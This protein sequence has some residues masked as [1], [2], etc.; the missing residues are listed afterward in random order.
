MGVQVSSASEKDS[1]AAGIRF[2]MWTSRG[3]DYDDGHAYGQS[4]LA[5]VLF[6]RE[7]AT[8]LN[9]TGV[10]VR[11]CH[12]GIIYTGLGD[13]FLKNMKAKFATNMGDNIGNIA[14]SMYLVVWEN[15]VF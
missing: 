6:A 12:P 4:S 10:T 7:L 1:Y 11:S 13:T 15:S 14:F 2:D 5:R 3:A 8:R 9:G